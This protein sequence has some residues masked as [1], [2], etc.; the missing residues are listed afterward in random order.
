MPK[1]SS[2]QWLIVALFQLFYGFAVFAV[3]R[4]YYQRQ[5]A[6]QPAA[7][8]RTTPNPH[9][10]QTG[11]GG[12]T[13]Q[14]DAGSAIPESVVQKDPELLAQLGDERF[15]ER[16]YQD[17]I[18]IYRRVLEMRPDD[19]DTYNDLGLALHY[20]GQSQAALAALKKGAETNPGFQRIWLTLGFVQMHTEERPEAKFALQEAIR[21][22]AENGIGQ[23]AKRML[24]KLEGN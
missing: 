23:E 6:V 7:M 14:F 1:L 4:D 15:R 2:L 17:A 12:V 18:G 3:T 8:A 21:L 10:G 19:V 16:R 11:S 9:T 20:S 24:E 5:G 13:R 22:G